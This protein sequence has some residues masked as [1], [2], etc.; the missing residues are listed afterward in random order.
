MI[1]APVLLPPLAPTRSARGPA[2]LSLDFRVHLVHD[3]NIELRRGFSGDGGGERL[4]HP[5]HRSA[6]PAELCERW[7]PEILAEQL[8]ELR[9]PLA[10]S[11]MV[12]MASD[13]LPS[14]T[15]CS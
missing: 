7:D 10:A 5:L 4:L 6:S 13:A 9:P 15:Y 3:A 2:N 12:G 8:S 14:A 1:A 11:A